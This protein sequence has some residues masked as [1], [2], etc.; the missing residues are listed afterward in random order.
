MA[1]EFWASLPNPNDPVACQAVLDELK[2][3]DCC[4]AHEK[5]KPGVYSPWIETKISKRKPE[6]ECD[7]RHRG[8]W[9]CR[10]HPDSTYKTV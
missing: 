2:T 1:D 6:C 8:R 4:S 3:C 5:D 10:R 9:V 7:C